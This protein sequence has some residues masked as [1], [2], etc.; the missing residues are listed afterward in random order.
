VPKTTESGDFIIEWKGIKFMFE[1]KKVQKTVQKPEVD[2]AEVNKAVRDFNAKNQNCDVLV[3]VSEDIA[4]S[5][6][7]SITYEDGR[8]TGHLDWRILFQTKTKSFIWN[9]WEKWPKSSPACKKTPKINLKVEMRLSTTRIKS[10]TLSSY[11][12]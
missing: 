9:L 11:S 7:A 6:I 4:I 5:P 8:S 1:N 3:F 12:I 10:T 2:E